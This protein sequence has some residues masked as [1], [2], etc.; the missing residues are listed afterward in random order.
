MVSGVGRCR[1]AAGARVLGFMCSGFLKKRGRYGIAAKWK[2]RYIVLKDNKLW[3]YPQSAKL[4]DMP[5]GVIDLRGAGVQVSETLAPPTRGALA[6]TA[7]AL[8]RR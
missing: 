6:C 5:R 7:D 8:A 2:E 1:S 3:Y 4:T